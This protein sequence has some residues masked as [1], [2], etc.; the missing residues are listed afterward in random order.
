MNCHAEVQPK[1]EQ[2]QVRP[3][4][5]ELLGHWERSEPVRWNKVYDLADFVYFDHSRHIAAGVACQECH[6][7]VETMEHVRREHG[8]KMS[9]CLDCHKLKPPGDVLAT[10]QDRSTRAPINCTVCHR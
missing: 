10:E 2:G 7:P 4:I 9:W 1:D 3:E 8:M 6:G 5:A